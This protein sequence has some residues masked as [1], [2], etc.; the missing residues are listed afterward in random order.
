MEDLSFFA[1]CDHKVMEILD[2]QG[3]SP[4]FFAE[5]EYESN[6]N[7]QGTRILEVTEVDGLC[8]FGMVDVGI[9]NFYFETNKKIIFGP[10]PIDAG[11]QFPDPDADY[12]PLKQYFCQ[13]TSKED[14]C[15]KCKGDK[16]TFDISYDS[17]SRL[18]T[19]EGHEKIKQQLLKVLMTLQGTNLFDSD[20]GAGLPNLVGEKVDQYLAARV[21]FTIMDAIN[22]LMRLQNE[23]SLPDEER[24]VSISNIDVVSDKYDPRNLIIKVTVLSGDYKEIDSSITLKL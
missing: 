12:V 15:P 4:N 2:V 7:I 5:L 6:R 24:I 13:Y 21:Q 3:S 20:Y 11:T 16:R 9:T 17:A 1:S 19:I 22:H 14:E 8:F 23:N 10:N 18:K